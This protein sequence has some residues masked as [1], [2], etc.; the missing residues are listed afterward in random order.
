MIY[1]ICIDQ[2]IGISNLYSM[3]QKGH[4]LKKLNLKHIEGY[5]TFKLSEEVPELCLNDGTLS[6]GDPIHAVIDK[7]GRFMG[8]FHLELGILDFSDVSDPYLL[9]KLRGAAS[10]I[11]SA[12]VYTV[13]DFSVAGCGNEMDIRT[14]YHILIE[15]VLAY[16]KKCRDIAGGRFVMVICCEESK[17]FFQHSGFHE[18]NRFGGKS[19]GLLYM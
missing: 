9:S 3:F 14:R 19:V 10:D 4:V 12:T 6:L 15:A 11:T 7:Y 17:V 16:V 1:P 5:K 8:C 18:I 2:N 13:T